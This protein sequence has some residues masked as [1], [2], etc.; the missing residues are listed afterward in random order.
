MHRSALALVIAVTTMNGGCAGFFRDDE[1]TS[2]TSPQGTEG[3]DE[4]DDDGSAADESSSA[5]ADSTTGPE[6]PCSVHLECGACVE[7]PPFECVFCGGVCMTPPQDADYEGAWCEWGLVELGSDC[8]VQSIPSNLDV[9][10]R[11]TANADDPRCIDEDETAGSVGEGPHF[12][13]GGIGALY[14]G[15]LDAAQNRI[16]LAG[17][18]NGPVE[19]AIVYA[20][21]LATGDRTVISGTYLDPLQGDTAFGSGPDLGSSAWDVEPHPDG[22]WWVVGENADFDFQLMRV[23]PTNG[24][25][26]LV[27]AGLV[28]CASPYEEYLAATIVDL[29]NPPS[30]AIAADGRVIVPMHSTFDRPNDY[31][32]GV[33][34]ETGVCT[35]VTLGSPEPEYAVGSGPWAAREYQAVA[36]VDG[37]LFASTRY[38]ELHSIDT[39]TG[40]RTM[41]SVTNGNVTLGDGPALDVD[42]LI[43]G[44]D[45]RLWT[46]GDTGGGGANTDAVFVDVDLETANRTMYGNDGR[47]PIGPSDSVRF[48]VPHP[49]LPGVAIGVKESAVVL[50][51]YAPATGNNIVLSH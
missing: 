38:G 39:V 7:T 29:S 32:I 51:E 12:P 34:D 31:G 5:A 22:S 40:N 25:R 37:T 26:E 41:V 28:T 45:G 44:V 13:P 33:I 46:S 2:G 14:G 43:A 15:F 9:D 21:D 49:T 36:I 4:G 50:F 19:H 23:D 27:V 10:C 6:D 3:G 48:V 18:Q 1:G 20:V 11:A 30:M 47:G 24:A 42:M 8:D 17:W 16:V 35:I